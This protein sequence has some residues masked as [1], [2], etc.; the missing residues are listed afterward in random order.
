LFIFD[1]KFSEQIKE[2]FRKL[3]ALKIA[4]HFIA[5]VRNKFENFCNK[6]AC[7]RDKVRLEEE[8]SE[9]SQL[10]NNCR[11]L[12]HIDNSDEDSREDSREKVLDYLHRNCTNKPFKPKE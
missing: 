1:G 9:I 12:L 7:E 6:E 2:G 8:N 3:A 11:K 4:N 5:V 10:L